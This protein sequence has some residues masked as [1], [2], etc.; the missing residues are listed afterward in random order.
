MAK[1]SGTASML[2]IVSPLI[3]IQ[4]GMFYNI[5]YHLERLKTEKTNPVAEL[6][7]SHPPIPKRLRF[8]DRVALKIS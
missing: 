8:L 1:E 6:F 7:A 2:F 4:G 3:E 5:D